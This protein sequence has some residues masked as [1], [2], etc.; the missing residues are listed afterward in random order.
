MEDFNPFHACQ[1]IGEE[2]VDHFE[3]IEGE[4]KWTELMPFVSLPKWK[5]LVQNRFE[6]QENM[7]S[8]LRD[9]EKE[10]VSKMKTI[11]KIEKN[12]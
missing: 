8:F 11:L 3:L 12:N 10:A 5:L 1:F 2:H 4:L 7:D 9:D 6:F